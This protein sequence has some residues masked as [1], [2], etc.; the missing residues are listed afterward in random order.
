MTS[1]MHFGLDTRPRLQKERT[2]EGSNLE[3]MAAL[4]KDL[5]KEWENCPAAKK[6]E[7]E[8]KAVKD[9]ERYKREFAEY[10]QKNPEAV[11]EHEERC[12]AARK[13]KRD[14]LTKGPG[15]VLMKKKMAA[16]EKKY[17]V[18]PSRTNSGFMLYSIENRSKVVKDKGL[19]GK[20]QLEAGKFI[21]EMW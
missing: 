13:K 9:K 16:L 2:Y 20:R 1:F 17:S 6:K 11:K 12:K 15:S 21:G 3:K 18:P 4:G 7:Y 5:A 14:H 8:E 19:E 10:S